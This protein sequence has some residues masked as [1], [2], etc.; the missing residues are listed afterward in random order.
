MRRVTV[1]FICAMIMLGMTLPAWG[2]GMSILG[3][4]A[5]AKGMGGAFRAVANDW[6]AAY[7]NPAGFIYM[8][9]SQLTVNEVISQYRAQY[10]PDVTYGGYPVGYYE[11]NIYNR[12]EILT[13]PTAGGFFK[14]PVKNRDFV[15]GL[16][17]FQ[18]FDMNVAWQ[19]FAP[20][21]NGALLPGQQI[22]HNFD[23][24]AFNWVGSFELMTNR[25]SVG[26]SAGVL[27][28]DLVYGGFFLRPNPADPTALYYDQVASRPNELITEWQ[29]VDGNGYAPNARI[30]LLFKATPKLNI[31]ATYAMKTKV[32]VD[33]DADFRYYM[34]DNPNY[35]NRSD[36]S[37]YRD[38]IFYILS[39]GV[40]LEAEGSYETEIKL[41]S[42]LAGGVA[43]QVS[44][45]LLLAADA[46]YT[47]WSE[48]EGYNFVYTFPA[49]NISRSVELDTWLKQ[50][51]TVPVDWKNALRGS[52]G[53]EYA[54]NDMIKLRTGYSF[55]Q[56][57]VEDGTMHPAFFDPG[58][59]HSF[60]LGLGLVFENII[61]DFATQYIKY[62]EITET[63]N[64]Y[65]NGANDRIVDN[66]AGTYKGTA[67]ESV[68][69]FTVR[70]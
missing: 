10:S 58:N 48:F 2:G 20:I 38:S 4:G 32:T 9:E 65:L 39:S 18:P 53:V 19:V 27:K 59:K 15:T 40:E 67:W 70:F 11:G 50:N 62:S 57:A 44:D 6:S 26:W 66:M 1:I 63:G 5:K 68:L 24:V 7:Y 31:G 56:S 36:V 69:Q 12:Y 22:E 21:N 45:K 17:I 8:T 42:Q 25:L 55:D 52:F 51:M 60:N 28:A 37:K 41:P 49:D 54:Y 16:A 34:P 35:N 43:Y 64:V 61:L 47:L 33:G 3:V 13:N 23:A 46:E 29:R 30:G 14:L